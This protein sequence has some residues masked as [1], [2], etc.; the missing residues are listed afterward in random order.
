MKYRTKTKTKRKKNIK[1]AQTKNLTFEK[2][3]QFEKPVARFI[4]KKK[5]PQNQ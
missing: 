1:E 2:M 3:K 5:G 4:K